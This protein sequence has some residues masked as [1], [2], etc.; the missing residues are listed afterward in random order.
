MNFQSGAGSLSLP[1]SLKVPSRVPEIA[2]K[3]PDLEGFAQ[4]TLIDIYTG[5]VK[6]C[7]QTTLSNGWSM[8]QPAV[9]WATGAVAFVALLYALFWTLRPN[10]RGDAFRRLLDLIHLYQHIAFTGLLNLNYPLAYISFTLNFSWALGLAGSTHIQNSI[11]SLRNHTGGHAN[12]A[13]NPIGST[14][15]ALSPYNVKRDAFG[16]ISLVNSA[17]QVNNPATVTSAKDALPA[18]IA[19]YTNYLKISQ[20]NAFLTIFLT[21]LMLLAIAIVLILTFLLVAYMLRRK[22]KITCSF[23]YR[24]VPSSIML[25]VVSPKY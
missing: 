12:G 6:A 10:P 2:Y 3:V 1:S 22:G 11:D 5:E 17:P 13:E 19:T 15:R 4:A 25:S 16:A 9:S 21:M 8:R 23:S 20:E 14:N 7:V 18:G 24:V